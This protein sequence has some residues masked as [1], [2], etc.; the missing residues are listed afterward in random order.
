MH[1]S[2]LCLAAICGIFLS[3]D[4]GLQ[5]KDAPASKDSSRDADREA[6]LQSARDFAAAF[7]KG[8]AKAVAAL[9][10]EEGEY[11]SDDGTILRGRAAM[12]AAFA[13]HFKGHPAGKME[14]KVES[15]RFPSR[16]IADRG[17]ADLHDGQR[18]F[19]RLGMLSRGTCARGWQ[20]ADCTLPR[21]GCRREPHGRPG[22]ADRNLARPGQGP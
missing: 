4:S 13:A 22:L 5:G 21:M 16:D 7:E 18:R 8:D 14:I 10:T 19:A 20:V 3:V 17:G 11:E 15:I 2:F 9:W 6:I 1:I 12:E